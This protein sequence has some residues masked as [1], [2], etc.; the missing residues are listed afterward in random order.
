MPVAADTPNELSRNINAFCALL[1]TQYGFPIGHAQAHDALRAAELVGITDRTR[2]RDALRAVCCGSH[3]EV[4][5]F[6]RAF[7]D[8][9][10][11]P[12]GI[13]QNDYYPRHTRPGHEKNPTPAGEQ[14]TEKRTQNEPD[15]SEGSGNAVAERQPLDDQGD[16]ANA[17]QALRARYSPLTASAP[18]PEI[19]AD[20]FAGML[21]AAN[22][23][24]DSVRRGRS[25]RW[26][27]LER[28]G[29]FD[30]RRTIRASLQ[31]G[32]D[33]IDMR[34]LGHPPRNPRF[35]LLIDASRSMA[36]HTDAVIH[37]SRALAR[38]SAR[39]NVFF[40]S[41]ELRD[42]TG[43]LR[44]LT[45]TGGRLTNLGAAWGGGTKI[46]ASLATFVRD[47]GR[48][49]LTPE[50][51]VIIFSDGLDVGDVPQLTTALREI[52]G[53][54]AAVVWLN[55][56]AATPGYAPVARGMRAALPF[57]SFLAYARNAREFEDLA[58]RL[59]RMPGIR[60]RR[61]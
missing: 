58:R 33:P 26:K 47:N 14:R 2:V 6:D 60:G 46:G 59:A 48:R 29:R 36:E 10:A 25:R 56:H 45:R 34:F 55:P 12:E 5:V 31:T 20:G 40:F 19:S 13:A 24:I 1:R 21:R 42:V 53:R 38:R 41:T 37:F 15:E 23:L 43:A 16:D 39:T 18:P 9:F 11:K 8:F 28:G 44:E 52:D 35:V 57:I 30:L 32:G 54:A 50:T 3:D 4:P 7:D 49:L 51:V 61:R 17:W 22:R 27:A